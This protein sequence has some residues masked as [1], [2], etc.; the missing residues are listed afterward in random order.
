MNKTISITQLNSY[1]KSI[2][3]GDVNLNRLFVVGEISNLTIHYKSGHIYLSLK[4]EKAVI[5]A[6]MFASSAKRMKFVPKDGMKV[7]VRGRVSVYEGSGQYQLYIDDMQPDG[8]GA[9]NLAYEQL[10]KN[11]NS[12]GLFDKENKKVLPFYP[13]KIAVITSSTGAAV[14]DIISILGRRWPIAKVNLYSCTVQG[15][16]AV[17][18]L[19]NSLKYADIDNNDVI[20]I[21]RGGGSLE[22]LWAFNSEELARNIYKAKTPVISAVGHEN[23]Y[24]ICDYVADVRA[25]TPSAAA[26][27]AVP[28]ITDEMQNI[29]AFKRKMNLLMNNKLENFN[30]RIDKLKP[31]DILMREKLIKFNDNLEQKH[32]QFNLFSR[33]YMEKSD[34]KLNN[35][36][37]SLDNLSPLKVMTRGYSVLQKNGVTVKK[38][39]DFEKDDKIIAVLT[40]GEV[41]L[42]V[43]D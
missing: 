19:L 17:P 34:N 35:L 3:D 33:I 41:S 26:E 6:V 42:K 15:E 9:L 40:D 36:M 14:R 12:E 11:L 20:I 24:T 23:D 22:D 8:L 30:L 37:I 5:K 4:D 1:I 31:T 32:R 25:A 27:L 21:G 39:S 2:L 16:N 28:N 10:W 18:E 29:L 38:S 13:K 7:L 43:L